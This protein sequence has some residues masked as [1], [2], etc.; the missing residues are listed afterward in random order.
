MQL[1]ARLQLNATVTRTAATQCNCHARV[2]RLQSKCGAGLDF[3]W[4]MYLANAH[5]AVANLAK[6][7]LL[8]LYHCSSS[9]PTAAHFRRALVE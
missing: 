7:A 6:A 1:Y 9:V 3:V 8:N 5:E 2:A 4:A